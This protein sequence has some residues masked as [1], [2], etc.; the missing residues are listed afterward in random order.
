MK[1]S[2][3]SDSELI[4]ELETASD[5]RAFEHILADARGSEGVDHLAQTLSGF[6]DADSE[7]DEWVVPELKEGYRQQLDIVE[8]T[9]SDIRN[10]NLTKICIDEDS[11]ELWYGAIN[12]A[13]L[14]LNER[15]HFDAVEFD[16]DTEE[17]IQLAYMRDQF[18]TALLSLMLDFIFMVD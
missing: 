11:V 17:V 3:T 4:I 16:E 18:Y 6:M 10:K 2:P 15:Y 14:M 1:I 5:A 12:L 7:W 9:L 13:R 8:E